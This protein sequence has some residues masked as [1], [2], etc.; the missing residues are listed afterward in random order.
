MG[1]PAGVILKKERSGAATLGL[2]ILT[3]LAAS[4]VGFFFNNAV[5]PRPVLN[6]TLIGMAFS[7]TFSNMV[8]E[9]RRAN[10]SARISERSS[11]NPRL[12]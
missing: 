9:A 4:G 2:L 11:Q 5:M 10:T 7:A 6:F 12:P 3:I 1:L 8:S